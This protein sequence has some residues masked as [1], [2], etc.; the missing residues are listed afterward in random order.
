MLLSCKTAKKQAIKAETHAWWEIVVSFAYCAQFT[1]NLLAVGVKSP[2][3]LVEIVLVGPLSASVKEH[4]Q[5]FQ[6]ILFSKRSCL[7]RADSGNF[8]EFRS[9][10]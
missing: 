5:C 7:C 9:Q 8:V 6:Y 1:L 4:G 10:M 2:I 3:Q